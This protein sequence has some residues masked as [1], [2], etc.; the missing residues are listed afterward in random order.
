MFERLVDGLALCCGAGFR[1]RSDESAFFGVREYRC[2]FDEVPR[3]FSALQ[4]YPVEP[5]IAITDNSA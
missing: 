4:Q 3:L 5:I 2:Q 1:I